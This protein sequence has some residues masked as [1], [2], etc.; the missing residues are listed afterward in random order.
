MLEPTKIDGKVRRFCV[1]NDPDNPGGYVAVCQCP[2]CSGLLLSKDHVSRLRVE[3]PGVPIA[4][5]CKGCG[6]LI[7]I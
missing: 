4:T 3:N 5:R 2:K 1:V 7:E 6:G